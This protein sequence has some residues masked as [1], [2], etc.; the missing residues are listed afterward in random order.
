MGRMIQIVGG[1]GQNAS[2]EAPGIPPDVSFMPEVCVDDLYAAF[3]DP[4]L[5][6]N[7]RM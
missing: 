7:A 4:A 1:L 3:T 2:P 5:A 6:S